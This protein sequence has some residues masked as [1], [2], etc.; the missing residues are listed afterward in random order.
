LSAAPHKTTFSAAWV[1][2]NLL[3]MLLFGW[4][5]AFASNRFLVDAP[6]TRTAVL[7]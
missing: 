1:I 2:E 4:I 7:R 5:I 6:P 3:A